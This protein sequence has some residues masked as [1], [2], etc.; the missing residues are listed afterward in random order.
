MWLPASAGRWV[1]RACFG[2][3]PLRSF[4]RTIVMKN[5]ARSE[6][7][8]PDT[9]TCAMPGPDQERLARIL[10]DYLVAIERGLPVTPE[11]LLEKY[12]EDADQLRGYLSGLQL[13]HA[14]AAPQINSS[15]IGGP[16]PQPSQTIGDYRLVR[17]IGR[18]GMGVVY[19]AWQQSLR[20]RVALKILPFSVA[21]DGKQ[22]SRFKNEAQAAAQ[23]QHPNI[24]PVYAVGEDQG[25]HFY[26]M[27][28]IEGQSLTSLLEG[29]RSTG[30]QQGDTTAPNC[31]DLTIAW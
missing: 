26:V 20:R 7:S 29:L 6:L 4:V 10:D 22:L 9:T 24:V 16:L 14:A 13:F 21:S 12:P 23:V 25:V 18:G 17:E 28:L 2:C 19:E 3:E 11:E 31:P 27:Q 15:I 30:H 5:P 8:S 1:L